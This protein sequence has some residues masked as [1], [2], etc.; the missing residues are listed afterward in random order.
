M[1]ALNNSQL[2]N[3]S[4][5]DFLLDQVKFGLVG[6]LTLAALWA[7]LFYKPFRP[8]WSRAGC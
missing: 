7:L 3:V 8:Y 4:R 5:A 6:I 2:V 1:N